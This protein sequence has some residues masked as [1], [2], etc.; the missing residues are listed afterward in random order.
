MSER[1]YAVYIRKLRSSQKRFS[2]IETAPAGGL[3]D[4]SQVTSYGR[5]TRSG[6]RK[7]PSAA[8]G[9]SL[10]PLHVQRETR[11]RAALKKVTTI[12]PARSSGA[13]VDAAN[14]AGELAASEG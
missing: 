1:N 6:G 4:T 9:P 14:R 3:V 2:V 12:P 7:V 10:R 5:R 13:V 11:R 8:S